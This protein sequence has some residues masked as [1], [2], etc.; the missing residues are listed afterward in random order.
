MVVIVVIE[1]KK[2]REEEGKIKENEDCEELG[3]KKVRKIMKEGEVSNNL[4]GSNV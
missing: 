1:R 2:V 3:K 4:G